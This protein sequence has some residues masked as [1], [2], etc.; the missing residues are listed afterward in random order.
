[1]FVVWVLACGPLTCFS[2]LC[3]LGFELSREKGAC[4]GKHSPLVVSFTCLGKRW[5]PKYF[6]LCT[7]SPFQV[8]ASHTLGN[9]S[10]SLHGLGNLL[11][12]Q[13]CQSESPWAQWLAQR[14]T[15]E[16][17]RANQGLH[18]NSY[19]TIRKR[20]PSSTSIGKSGGCESKALCGYLVNHVKR[21]GVVIKPRRGK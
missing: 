17:S 12:S 21:I 11:S 9:C 3:Q 13:R 8:S 20:S 10:S 1:M 6:L 5:C 19:M 4:G 16:Q 2:S 18:L 14:W 7:D 15:Y